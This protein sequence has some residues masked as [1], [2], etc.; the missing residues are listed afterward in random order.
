MRTVG[1]LNRD[2]L[3]NIY[4]AT[5]EVAKSSL[6]WG[7][8]SKSDYRD[9]DGK[10]GDF[11]NLLKVYCKKKDPQGNPVSALKTKD[12]RTTYWVEKVQI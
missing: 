10:K 2:D 1:S 4:K 8:M 11:E 5:K 6:E 7:G 12:G 9:I 3:K